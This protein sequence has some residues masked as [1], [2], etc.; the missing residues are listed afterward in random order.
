MEEGSD[1]AQRLWQQQPKVM[2]RV[3]LAMHEGT[4]VGQMILDQWNI[5]P[6]LS[7]QEDNKKLYKE[8]LVQVRET[9]KLEVELIPNYIRVAMKMM[10]SNGLGR[11]TTNKVRK[12]LNS[13]T[14]RQGRTYDHPNSVKEIPKFIEFHGIN[15]EEM[16][17]PASSFKNFNEFFFRKLKEGARP[18]AE[19][20][21]D[22]VAVSPA[23]S[24]FHVFPTLAE[25]QTF[26]VKGTSFSISS[27]VRDDALALERLENSK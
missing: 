1:L 14:E 22:G 18:V 23:D 8:I 12:V 27:L 26:W 6:K 5:A 21:N 4:N 9:G 13:M 10:Y 11:A 2:W 16:R 20:N 25:A 15:E 19:E 24:R 3:F 7:V 17:E